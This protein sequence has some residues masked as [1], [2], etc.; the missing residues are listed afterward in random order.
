MPRSTRSIS[1]LGALAFG[2]LLEGCVAP[3]DADAEDTAD[4]E[5]ALGTSSRL[6]MDVVLPFLSDVVDFDITT[7]D[8]NQKN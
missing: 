7:V 3:V 4:S 2:C 1:L 8:R 6:Q 5:A